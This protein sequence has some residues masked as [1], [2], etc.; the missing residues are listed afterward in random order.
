M[1][2]GVGTSGVGTSGLCILYGICS[3]SAPTPSLLGAYYMQPPEA[4]AI[5]YIMIYYI[6]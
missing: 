4:R 1:E 2:K 5:F 6:I 3:V